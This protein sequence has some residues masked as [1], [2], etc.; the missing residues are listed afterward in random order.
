[1]RANLAFALLFGLQAAPA[2]AEAPSYRV[3]GQAWTDF[4]RIMKASDSLL[5]GGNPNLMLDLT[6]NSLVSMGAQFTVE[7]ALAEHWEAAFGFGAHK[8]SHA[9]GRGE[10]SFLAISMY[11]HFLTESRL[12]WHAGDK[13][14]Q[15]VSVTL[16]SFPFKY[17]RDVQNLGL[18]LFRGPVYPGILMGGYQEFGADSTKST[19]LGAKFSHILGNFSHDLIL[20]SERDIPPTFDLSLGYVARL[21]LFGALELGA[22]V[23][24][25]RLVAYDEQLLTPGK[26]SNEELNFKK[27]EYVEVDSATN[28]TV[29]FTH[30]GI[31]VGGLASLDLKPLF[32]IESMG[33]DEMKIYSEAAV[34]GVQNYGKTYN[35]IAKRI[36]VMF[37]IS[38][39]TW[40]LL[41]RLSIEVEHYRSPYRNDLTRVGYNNVVADWTRQEHRIPSPKPMLN[42]DYKITPDG[43]W[44][45]VSGDTVNVAGTGLTRENNSA[46]DLKWSVN[47]EKSLSGHIRF[48]A[49]V[50][51]DHYRPRPV[52]T[53]LIT[54][55]GGTSEAFS[56]KSNW[57]FMLRMG[58]FF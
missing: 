7:A 50:A 23:N 35:D 26:L 40:K 10:T 56:E 2:L 13:E 24:L 16:G 37:G 9:R 18:Y 44:V 41:D 6:G 28:D 55:N 1:M 43:R 32:G 49:Q 46:D 8:V 48:A 52:S 54:S 15:H 38:L 25:Y 20:N 27:D 39:P 42:A 21:K 12:T 5:P 45:N 34:L 30:R 36:P 19:Q 14:S 53:N 31:K 4:G 22:G 33:K 58:Y 29:F 17:N 11:H 57:Y 47:L 3:T 51:N